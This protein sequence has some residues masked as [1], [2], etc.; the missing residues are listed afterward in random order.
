MPKETYIDLEMVLVKAK[1]VFK[2]A[3]VATQSESGKWCKQWYRL[4]VYIILV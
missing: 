1:K 3:A 4:A 2:N